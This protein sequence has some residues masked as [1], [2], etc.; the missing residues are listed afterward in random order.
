MLCIVF[1][2]HDENDAVM[3]H[4]PE[5][6]LMA[7]PVI[8]HALQLPQIAPRELHVNAVLYDGGPHLL[9]LPVMGAGRA[10]WMPDRS[11]GPT[12]ISAMPSMSSRGTASDLVQCARL[13][14]AT[15]ALR[16]VP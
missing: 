12:P 1:N 2:L 10:M 7:T 11:A 4:A 3:A 9:S 5:G 15:G 6:P 14:A 8:Q 13:R 16:A